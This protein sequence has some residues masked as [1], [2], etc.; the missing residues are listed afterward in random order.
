MLKAGIKVAIQDLLG[1]HPR[2]VGVGE[3]L[4]RGDL[5]YLVSAPKSALYKPT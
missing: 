3:V 1:E 2:A 4:V 5:N